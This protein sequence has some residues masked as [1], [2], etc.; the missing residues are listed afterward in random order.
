[1]DLEVEDIQRVQWE[2]PEPL[3]DPADYW[4]R[5]LDYGFGESLATADP[6][7]S[8]WTRPFAESAPPHEVSA[9]GMSAPWDALSANWFDRL[10]NART[11]ALQ[12]VVS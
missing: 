12:C 11:A 4:Q 8:A 1:M 3:D 10:T 2:D 5:I 6:A 7:A 9:S